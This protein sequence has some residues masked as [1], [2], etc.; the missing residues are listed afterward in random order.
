MKIAVAYDRDGT[1]FQHFGHSEYFKIYDVENKEV[2]SSEIVSTDGCGH[3]ALADALAGEG[4]DTLICGGIG[5]GAIER[6]KEY[7]I[8]VFP[9]VEG[10]ADKAVEDFLENNLLYQ[11]GYV[12]QEHEQHH[13]EGHDCHH[14]GEGHDC[15]HDGGHG[16][17]YCH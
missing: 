16:G 3:C 14:S 12:C 7:K 4:V 1:V 5:G 17:G 6:M 10:S 8:T 11:E 9:G 13:A 15:H 2:I